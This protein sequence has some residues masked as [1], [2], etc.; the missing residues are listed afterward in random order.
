MPEAEAT[1]AKRRALEPKA[2]AIEK[3]AGSGEADRKPCVD[4]GN[5]AGVI[6]ARVEEQ[7]RVDIR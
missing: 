5:A 6:E 7:A 4:D 3:S 1:G 2:K